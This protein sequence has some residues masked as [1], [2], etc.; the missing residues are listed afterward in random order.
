MFACKRTHKHAS[1]FT[2][3][4]LAWRLQ[5]LQDEVARES[6]ELQ[7]LQ[8]QRQK[9]Q[10]ALEEL[11]QQ[12]GSLEEQLTH[13]R[14]QTSQ[15]TQLV[16]L[17][18]SFISVLESTSVVLISVTR[19]NSSEWYKL[20]HNSYICH[21]FHHCSRSM[22]SRNRGYASMKRSWSR[23]ERSSSLCRR[24]AGGCRRRSRPLRSS[25]HLCRNLSVIPLHKLHR[26]V[27]VNR[28]VILMKCFNPR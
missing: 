19:I 25:S 15:E 16:G 20:F 13:I 9:V 6:E 21:R 8:A 2:V 18:D 5:D 12:K 27:C 10:Q 3:S 17:V 28:S 1:Y 26:L 11:D 4:S 22:R 14:Q 24:R 23:P 7:Q